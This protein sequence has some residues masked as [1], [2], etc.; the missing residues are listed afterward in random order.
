VTDSY[1]RRSL[2][3]ALVLCPRPQ[4][5]IAAESHMSESRLSRLATCRSAPTPEERARLAAV[6]GV[7]ED[8][9]FGTDACAERTVDD[10]GGA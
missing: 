10:D 5:M 9:L 6:L 3:L 2:K 1:R 4:Y 7:P 8:E